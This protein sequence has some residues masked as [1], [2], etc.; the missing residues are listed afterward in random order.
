MTIRNDLY[1][2]EENRGQLLGN[3]PVDIWMP[4]G[5]KCKPKVPGHRLTPS[6][7]GIARAREL[8]GGRVVCMGCQHGPCQ[9]PEGIG[10]DRVL[11]VH[12]E[13]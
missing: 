11:H 4:R 5:L 2:R 12:K 3:G 8:A 13:A 1:I 7:F 9:V 10:H 6:G